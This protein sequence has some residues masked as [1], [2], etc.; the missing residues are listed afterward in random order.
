[1][2]RMH[3]TPTLEE[4][5]EGVISSPVKGKNEKWQPFALVA[6]IATLGTGTLLAG[7]FNVALVFVVPRLIT[8]ED[9]G[10]WRMFG[11]Y[12]GYVGFLHLGFADG[13]LLRWAG[14][15]MDEFHQEIASALTYLF[16][17]QAIVLLPMCA[18][19]AW[20][21]PGPLKFISIAV[22]TYALILNLATVLQ[23][24]LQSA[25]IF[26]PVAI[27]TVAAPA[28]FLGFI[29][30]WRSRW[31]SDYREVISLY[32]VGWLIVLAFL[33]AWTK[34]WSGPRQAV[35][36]KSLA[37]ECVKSGWPIVI[38]TGG[39]MLI[40]FADRLA[41]S[42]STSIQNF[43]QY[44][45]AASAMAV[46]ITAIQTCSKVCFSHLAGVTRDGRKRIYGIG[47]RFLLIAWAVLL[48]YYFAL[49][50]FIRRFLPQYAPSL[51]Y[52]RIL[53]LGIPF[54]AAVQILQMSYAYLNGWQQH[55]LARTAVVLTISLAAT[56]FAVICTG[57]LGVV[58]A[59]QVGLLSGWWLFNEWTLRELTGQKDRDWMKFAGVYLFAASSYWFTTRGAWPIPL[60]VLVY[61][62]CLALAL[63]TICGEEMRLS[64]RLMNHITTLRNEDS[65]ERY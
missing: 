60:S 43:A 38:A 65:G 50:L 52:A 12:A 24:G 33:L 20:I 42:W 55:Y 39:T 7:L 14:R 13:A 30:L 9:Y 59:A 1:M 5:P 23:Y 54:L 56:S 45:L 53:L 41:V 27:S 36:I 35:N 29:L 32:E 58:A 49:E 62:V 31:K 64:A 16:F 17:Q 6:D 21:L 4:R 46:P 61:Y 34:L 57:S 51:Q 2:V 47:S 19:A 8:V 10:Y 18:I 26:R 48:P 40:S 11:L 22:A 25:K 37:K 3:T 63:T 15:P 44:S 28:L